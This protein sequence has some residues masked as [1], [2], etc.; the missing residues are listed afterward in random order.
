MFK[1]ISRKRIRREEE[2]ALGLD[3]E[4]KEALGL[5]GVDSDSDE[6]EQSD[7]DSNEDDGVHSGSSGESPE[8]DG[9]EEELLVEDDADIEDTGDK[10]EE[11]TPIISKRALK[12]QTRQ[13]QIQRLRERKVKWKK[14]K[15]EVALTST[16]KHEPSIVSVS[17]EPPKLSPTPTTPVKNSKIS[18]DLS[19]PGKPGRTNFSKPSKPSTLAPLSARGTDN[20][21]DTILVGALESAYKPQSRSQLEPIDA[22]TA[23]TSSSS[24]GAHTLAKRQAQKKQDPMEV[25]AR[26]KKGRKP[27]SN[28]DIEG[29]NREKGNAAK[30]RMIEKDM[31]TK[32]AGKKGGKAQDHWPLSESGLDSGLPRKKKRRKVITEET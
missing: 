19:I 12:K 27:G 26:K 28:E 9:E 8:G 30:E 32:E 14:T 3:E 31:K 2:E 24:K 16:R 15:L 22:A 10:D 7:S 13:Q 6:S 18:T 21:I 5:T 29:F 25:K 11:I 23:I 4:V 17:S 1:R 20:S